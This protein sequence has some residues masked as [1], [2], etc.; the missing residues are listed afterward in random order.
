MQSCHFKA[1][2]ESKARHH[3]SR[4]ER[5]NN[6]GE[7]VY[8]EP[9]SPKFRER[10]CKLWDFCARKSGI[11][12]KSFRE[13]HAIGPLVNSASHW[14]ITGRKRRVWGRGGEARGGENVKVYQGNPERRWK[15]KLTREGG[16]TEWLQEWQNATLT[17]RPRRSVTWLRAN[18]AAR[19]TS[20]F[21]S[22]DFDVWLQITSP[23]R[24]FEDYTLILPPGGDLPGFAVTL[25][26]LKL[27]P[28]YPSARHGS[29]VTVH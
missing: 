5:A 14:F 24:L 28:S 23:D 10:N 20:M 19:G 13:R 9:G 4:L 16:R 11:Y 29:F 15:V 21:S 2:T 3:A 12:G 22:R 27:D 26:G 1:L 8:A 25:G 18:R 17:A 6:F 7:R